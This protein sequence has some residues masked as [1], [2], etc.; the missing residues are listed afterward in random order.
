MIRYRPPCQEGHLGVD[1]LLRLE[2]TV[3]GVMDGTRSVTTQVAVVSHG[4]AQRL[5]TV[6]T[7][8]KSVMS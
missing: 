5:S 7:Y 8:L 6:R 2:S 3:A 4:Q 1:L